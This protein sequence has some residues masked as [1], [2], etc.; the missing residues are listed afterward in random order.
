M[1]RGVENS[2]AAPEANATPAASQA[3][4]LAA[5][6]RGGSWWSPSSMWCRGWRKILGLFAPGRRT[7]VPAPVFRSTSRFLPLYLISFPLFSCPPSLIFF[8]VPGNT[9]ESGAR[10]VGFSEGSC[11]HRVVK[12][13]MIQGGDISAGDGTGENP[14]MD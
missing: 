3:S 14:S 13:F 7:S 4:T 9:A 11:F 12:G 2:A 5:G 1:V 8:F 10:S 6:W